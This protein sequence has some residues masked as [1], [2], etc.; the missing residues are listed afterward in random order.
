TILDAVEDVLRMLQLIKGNG[1]QPIPT[2]SSAY[3][4][5][6]MAILAAAQ[7]DA[8]PDT[9]VHVVDRLEL[10][11][12]RL[13]VYQLHSGQGRRMLPGSEIDALGQIDFRHD[14]FI[15]A[16]LHRSWI[17][18]PLG[19]FGDFGKK[20]REWFLLRLPEFC[21]DERSECF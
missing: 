6:G 13:G 20:I 4:S 5:N 7:K 18:V 3:L 8:K 2:M 19:G 21:G 14:H 11:V 15:G 12:I 16:E 1:I 10:P 9:T 17:T